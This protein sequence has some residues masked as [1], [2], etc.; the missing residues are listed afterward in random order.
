M[1]ATVSTIPAWLVSAARVCCAPTHAARVARR[2]GAAV[3]AGSLT[4]AA[5]CVTA[6]ARAAE[7]DATN[8]DLARSVAVTGR[9]AFNAG[10]YETALALF[11][12][13]Y[14]LFPAPTI[15]LYEARALEKLGLLIEAVEVY[16]KLTRLPVTQSAPLQFAEAIDA[17]REEG[18][19]LRS[20][21]PMLTL[22]L[23]GVRSDDPSVAV[24]VNGRA[25]NASEL[26]R[27]QNI[28]P[29]TYHI[30]S[31]VG[32]VQR[33]SADVTL[34]PGQSRRVELN[35][36]A[37]PMAPLPQT[38]P[39]AAMSLETGSGSRIP[40]LAYVAGGIGL[41]GVTAGV[42]TGLLANDHYADAE[43]QC[44]SGRCEA[45]TPGPDA[46]DAFRTWRMVSSVSY[47]VGAAG[48]AAG[49]VLWLTASDDP[50]SGQVGSIEPW[51]NAKAAGIRGTF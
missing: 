3:C 29:G 35:V 8:L 30:V 17:A 41:A 10:D 11:R 15:G 32:G 4:L 39:S 46:V 24:T 38:D 48:I 18:E 25:V 9:E 43:E 34:M 45:G 12:R 51:G 50:E 20:R 47:G 16:S 33:A 36:D 23:R 27:G 40:G 26:G 2:W 42:I 6:P 31:T 44:E 49:V 14:A 37:A 7:P 5:L 13:A 22:E 1:S 28:N 21:I 19:G